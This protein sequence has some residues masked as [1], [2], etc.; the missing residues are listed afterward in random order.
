MR[1]SIVTVCYNSVETLGDTVRSVFGQAGVDAEHVIV[2]GGSTD[3]TAEL[4]AGYNGQ[5]ARFVS[6]PDE[7]IYDA[8][9]RGIHGAESET[10]GFLN[11]DRAC[12]DECAIRSV[13]ACAK[14]GKACGGYIPPM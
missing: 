3:G 5:I 1:I 13:K 6:K 4:V 7:G 11:K 14:A 9:N 12:V 2:D 10:G 8:M